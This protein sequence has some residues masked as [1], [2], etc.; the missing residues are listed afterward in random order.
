MQHVWSNTLAWVA[1]VLAALFLAL[2]A[3]TES[4]V[5]GKLPSLQTKFLDERPLALPDGLPADRTLALVSF[6]RNQRADVESWI[7]GLQLGRD[8]S[9]PWLRMPVLND[10]GDDAGRSAIASR[11]RSHYVDDMSTAAVVPV[12]T[13]RSA[14]VRAARLSGVERPSVLVLN[15][16]GEVVAR[17][18]GKFDAGKAETLRQSLRE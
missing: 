3:P 7:S 15:R 14:F 5:M 10:P 12:F 18:E 6:H 1:A 8:T 16:R 13:D 9:I 17:V 11:I 2:A 4:S